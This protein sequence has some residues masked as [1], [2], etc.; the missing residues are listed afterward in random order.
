MRITQ[1]ISLSNIQ[2][3]LSYQKGP[4]SGGGNLPD[5]PACSLIGVTYKVATIGKQ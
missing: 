1:S 3:F 5:L 2:T 4:P